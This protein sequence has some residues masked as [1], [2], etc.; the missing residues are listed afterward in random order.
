MLGAVGKRVRTRT[1]GGTEHGEEREQQPGRVRL[2]VWLDCSHDLARQPV[3][4]CRIER[5]PDGTDG[6]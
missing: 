3:K 1:D 2:G 6:V 4:R 5:Q